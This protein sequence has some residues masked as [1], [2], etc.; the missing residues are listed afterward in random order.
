MVSATDVKFYHSN[1]NRLG[2]GASGTQIQHANPRNLFLNV[3]VNEVA[4]GIDHYACCFLKNTSAETM[5][6]FTLWL[7]SKT[8]PFDTQIKWGFDPLGKF[9][10]MGFDG[11]NDYLQLGDEATLWSQSKSRFAFSFR[12]WANAWATGADRDLLRHNGTS[13][14]RFSVVSLAGGDNV[15]FQIKDGS[16]AT[17]TC[18]IP[19]VPLGET[20]WITCSYDSTLGSDNM[21][22]FLDDELIDSADLTGNVNLTGNLTLGG[23]NTNISHKGYIRD[24][25]YY[26]DERLTQDEVVDIIED[27]AN[28]PDHDYRL[29][30]GEGTGEPVDSVSGTKTGVR[31]NGADWVN[32][33]QIIPDK[34]TEPKGV[35]WQ[36]VAKKPTTP[37]FGKLKTNDLF[38]IWLWLH[39]DPGAKYRIDDKCS[40]QFSFKVAGGGTGSPGGGTGGGTGGGSG[41]N[42]PPTTNADY[43]IAIIGDE[44]CA[45]ETNDVIDV[46]KDQ[47]Y[48]YVISVGDHAYEAS[49]CWLDRF[50]FLRDA[51]KFNSAYGNH[52]Y[53]ESGGTTPYKS[54]FGHNNT[55]FTFK[56]KNIFF[57]V[58]DTN[59]DCDPGS[60]QHDFITA[61]LDAVKNDSSITWKIAVMHHPWFGT[62]AE[63][64]ANESNQVQAFHRLFQNNRVTLLFVGHNHNWQRSK[65]VAYN[66]SAPKEP[67]VVDSSSPF[68][69]DTIALIQVV[70]G[71]S[72][73]DDADHLYNLPS[74][75]DFNGFQNKNHN[76]LYELIASNS[77]NTLTGRFR[78]TD[79]KTYDTIVINA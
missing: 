24:F 78:D 69:R 28:A 35:S 72:G 77:G 29:S 17:H 13:N 74:S 39:V 31:T 23:S 41:G 42:P 14:W 10:W 66:S 47:N 58:A 22:I 32:R 37:N 18:G 56:F 1:N 46:L 21:T 61:Q 64:P 26:V 45:S 52:E 36:D 38:A 59:R 11:S 2:G 43:K 27:S 5:E 15:Q 8:P 73:H 44:G 62:G 48:D 12:V 63:H 6:S 19:V 50:K 76:G 57:L 33:A 34:F 4:T 55:Y 7:A 75:A 30:M 3:P 40:M 16:G 79:N 70:S 53:S 68:E 71:T 49:K 9:N 60:P 65:M 51:H 67:K 20:H 25:R 54:F